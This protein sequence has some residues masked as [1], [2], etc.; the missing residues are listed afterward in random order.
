MGVVAD[1]NFYT[2]SFFIDQ[3]IVMVSG[4]RTFQETISTSD[5]NFQ[6]VIKPS[7]VEFIEDEGIMSVDFNR[8]GVNYNLSIECDDYKTD[9]R[10]KEEDFLR[11]LYNRLVMIGGKK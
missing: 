11:N 7:S 9:K 4:D 8:H 3:A 10:C 5:A 6:K 1:K 2:I